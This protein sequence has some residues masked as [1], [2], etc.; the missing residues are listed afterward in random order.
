MPKYDYRCNSCQGEFEYEHRMSDDPKT[1][2]EVCG[3]PLERLISATAFHLKGGGW[4]KDLYSST[5]P[6]ASSD[7]SSS[8]SAGTATPSSSTAPST[9][10]PSAPAAPAP[11]KPAGSDKGSGSSGSG[12]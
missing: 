8:T 11:A 2:C 3:G 5:K 4:Y 10:A 12:T 9:P 1:V 7:T 6:G